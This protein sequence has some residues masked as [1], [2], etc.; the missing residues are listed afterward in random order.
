MIGDNIRKFRKERKMTQKTLA[1]Q[2]GF[3]DKT[4]SQWELGLREPNL[5]TITKLTEVLNITLNELLKKSNGSEK[6]MEIHQ[7]QRLSSTLLSYE[8]SRYLNRGETGCITY[9]IKNNSWFIPITTDDGYLDEMKD[10]LPNDLYIVLKLGNHYGCT[11]VMFDKDSEKIET[12]QMLAL[13]TAHISYESYQ[14]LGSGHTDFLVYDKEEY[15]WFIPIVTEDSHL[16]LLKGV[17]PSD[18]YKVLI[19]AKHHGF[20]W[21]MLDCDAERIDELP[22]F[23]W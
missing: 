20:T 3:E 5:G 13:S 4:I 23:E 9:K 6:G 1:K 19:F 17:V 16:E 7:M 18:L 14:Y 2:L 15:G 21:V 10:F 12:H 22:K 11:W 8:T